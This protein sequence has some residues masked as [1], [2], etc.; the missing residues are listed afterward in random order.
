MVALKKVLGVQEKVTLPVGEEAAVKVVDDPE[1]IV[2]L[3]T[4]MVGVVFTVTV[5]VFEDGQPPDVLWRI[6]SC[7]GCCS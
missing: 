7:K 1:Q 6:I 2:E 3:L 4:V 5:L